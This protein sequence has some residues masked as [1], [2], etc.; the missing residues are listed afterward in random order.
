MMM[1]ST[2]TKNMATLE[3]LLA[4][5]RDLASSE[6][7]AIAQAMT[8]AITICQSR[9]GVRAGVNLQL[10]GALLSIR[11]GRPEDAVRYL[12]IAIGIEDHWAGIAQA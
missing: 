4:D 10:Q 12:E 8:E 6:Y 3:Q 11:A 1:N 7:P 9:H 5:V 2:D